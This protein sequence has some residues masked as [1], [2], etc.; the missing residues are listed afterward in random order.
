MRCRQFVH[1]NSASKPPRTNGVTRRNST[2]QRTAALRVRLEHRVSRPR[3]ADVLRHRAGARAARQ[4]RSQPGDRPARTR[5][6]RDARMARS[7]AAVVE[8]GARGQGPRARK[9]PDGQRAHY[10]GNMRTWLQPILVSL[11]RGRSRSLRGIRR[12]L[13]VGPGSILEWDD[14]GEQIVVR[15]AGR[16]S[17][18]DVH[19]SLFTASPKRRT[20]KELKAGV[21]QH[22]RNRRAR[23]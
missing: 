19:R 14:Q 18:Q 5:D 23:S 11:H 9:R 6:R 15:R 20:L 16:Y 21:R 7:E 17:S 4:G 2:R 3:S 22:V 12:K 13:G 8:Q 1:R 10:R